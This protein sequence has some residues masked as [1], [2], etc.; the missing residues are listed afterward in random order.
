MKCFFPQLKIEATVSTLSICSLKNHRM[1]ASPINRPVFILAICVVL[2]LHCLMFNSVDVLSDEE[3][4][5]LPIQGKARTAKRR[6]RKAVCRKPEASERA[7]S[8]RAQ[9]SKPCAC[10]KRTCCSQFAAET[11][12]PAYLDYVNQWNSLTKLDQDRVVTLPHSSQFV[13]LIGWGVCL[14]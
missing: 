12:W 4:P 2:N 11:L 5:V 3:E 8:L 1:R 7:A 10:K 9:I 13:E 14:F 6:Q